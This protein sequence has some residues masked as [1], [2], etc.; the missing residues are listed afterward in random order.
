MKINYTSSL[1]KHPGLYIL[2]FFIC[3]H[4]TNAQSRWMVQYLDQMD[5]PGLGLDVSYDNGY[6]LS[7]WVTPNSPHYSWLIKTDINGQIL[8]KK[9]LGRNYGWTVLDNFAQ[10]SSGE[11]YLC[12]GFSNNDQVDPLIIKLDACG[13]KQWCYSIS[14]TSNNDFLS[15]ITMTKDDGC[16]TIINEAFRPLYINRNGLLRFSSDGELLWQQ[17]YQ[18]PDP[19]VNNE[20]LTNLILAPDQGFLLTG[21]C[22]YPDPENPYSW[23]HPYYVKVD[24]LGNFQW[25]IILHKETGDIGGEAF[26]TLLNPDSTCYYSCISHYYTSD[27]LYTTLPAIVKFDLQGNVLGVYNLVT[28]IYDLGKLMTF[29]FLNDSTMVGSAS[30]RNYDDEPNSRAIKFDTLGHITDSLT[31]FNDIFLAQTSVT[32]DH[33]ILYF[34]DTYLT[35][36][37]DAYLIK[38]NE[39]FQQDTVYT[40]P[41]VYDSLCQGIIKSDTISPTGCG[42]IVGTG[43][44]YGQMPSSQDDLS[45]IWPNPARSSV[46]FRCPKPGKFPARKM[47]LTVYDTFGRQVYKIEIPAGAAEVNIDVNILSPGIYIAI[48][49]IQY[50]DCFTR[51]ICSG[52]VSPQG[53]GNCRFGILHCRLSMSFSISDFTFPI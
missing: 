31:L 4:G 9:F 24:S 5:A 48:L 7:G 16:A 42:L 46:H 40:T 22:G 23:L 37:F 18:S 45:W 11:I 19:G 38:L 27:T 28:G 36:Q 21:T 34:I 35:G 30:W 15:S 41:F 12:G 39:D 49:E 10:N 14:N 53:R 29:D 47:N 25:E 20:D 6:L 32:S 33:K 26:M 13:N 2:L 52:E 50:H 8:W 51:E 3:I 17:Y 1:L 44:E 43:E